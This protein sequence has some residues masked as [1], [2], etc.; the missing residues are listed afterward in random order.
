M[1]VMI[2]VHSCHHPVCKVLFCGLRLCKASRW[3]GISVRC[4][5]ELINDERK[6]VVIL[7][8]CWII[9]QTTEEN[10][11]ERYLY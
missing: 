3:F 2:A 9:S 8:V 7:H 1:I 10:F 4:Q 11:P 6:E 5:Q